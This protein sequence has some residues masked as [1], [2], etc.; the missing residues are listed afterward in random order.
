MPNKLSQISSLLFQTET[1][2]SKGFE[3]VQVCDIAGQGARDSTIVA[4]SYVA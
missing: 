4:F 3:K 1:K 2:V